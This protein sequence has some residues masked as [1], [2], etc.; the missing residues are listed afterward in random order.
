MFLIVPITYYKLLLI[1]LVHNVLF[2]VLKV[3]T[4]MKMVILKLF[5][6][7]INCLCC[8]RTFIKICH[9]FRSSFNVPGV[10]NMY[11]TGSSQTCQIT[12]VQSYKVHDLRSDIRK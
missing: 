4:L 8:M 11:V 10:S 1:R 12:T 2:L 9:K 5:F 6:F 3:N 7:L